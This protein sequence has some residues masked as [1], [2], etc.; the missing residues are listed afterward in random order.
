MNSHPPRSPKLLGCVLCCRINK[1]Y[2]DSNK[3]LFLRLGRDSSNAYL[4]L[5]EI[6]TE[7]LEKLQGERL[8]GQA[9]KGSLER[10][11]QELLDT[12]EL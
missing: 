1:M 5:E 8:Y 3:K 12:M 6:V 4:T 11:A 2:E 10:E 7:N 9:P